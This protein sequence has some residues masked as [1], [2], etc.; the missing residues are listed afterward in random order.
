MEGFIPIYQVFGVGEIWK[1]VEKVVILC[2]YLA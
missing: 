2:V 1:F